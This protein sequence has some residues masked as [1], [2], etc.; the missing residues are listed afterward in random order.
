M[1]MN[2]TLDVHVA[3]K[4]TG[5][6]VQDGFVA[7]PKREYEKNVLKSAAYDA[8]TTKERNDYITGKKLKDD[9]PYVKTY[10]DGM[11]EE[12]NMSR[13]EWVAWN[14]IKLS[15]RKNSQFFYL[16]PTVLGRIIKHFFKK[17][18]DIYECSKAISGL[19][20]RLFIVN[21]GRDLYMV[22][23]KK[24]FNGDRA[25]I[26]KTHKDYNVFVNDNE[27]ELQDY[28]DSIK[29]NY[30]EELMS[31]AVYISQKTRLKHILSETK[32]FNLQ[33]VLEI[34]MG[35]NGDDL[36]QID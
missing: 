21:V 11:I 31:A 18:M 10:R 32:M 17:D 2:N 6:L 19:K 5:E 36:S 28:L 7:V 25:Y 35:L 1:E 29:F 30:E 20:K 12:Y 4:G 33:K 13:R 22:N 3:E 9:S 16:R 15:L 27:V 14:A 23:H 34:Q 24:A 8:I 26:L